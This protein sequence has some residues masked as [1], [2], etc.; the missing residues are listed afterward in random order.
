MVHTDKT[1]GQV[2]IKEIVFDAKEDLGIEDRWYKNLLRWAIRGYTDLNIYHVDF[3]E[4][5]KVTPNDLNIITVPDDFINLVALGF[6]Y[7]GR[8]YRLTSD[9]TF[10]TTTTTDGEDEILDSDEGEGV[11]IGDSSIYH[12][13]ETGGKNQ[14]YVT[15]INSRQFM[16]NGTPRISMILRYTSSGINSTGATYIPVLFREYLVEYVNVKYLERTNAS[17]IKI[18][19]AEE[20]M[21]KELEKLRFAQFMSV[22]DMADAIYS[23]WTQT[24]KR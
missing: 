15:W 20:R 6:N 16:I 11:A 17:D 12:Y 9:G 1:D 21:E 23:T 10:I 2:R 19:R 14:Y 8:F 22:E 18:R 4:E 3:Y 13:G 24:V 5:A 7:Y